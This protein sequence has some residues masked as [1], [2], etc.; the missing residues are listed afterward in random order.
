MDVTLYR[1]S[2]VY[3]RCRIITFVGLLHEDAVIS[4]CWIFAVRV[5][6]KGNGYTFMG[7]NFCQNCFASLLKREKEIICSP[8]NSNFFN[9][10]V[11]SFSEG[12]LCAGKR[13]K[14]ITL[15]NKCR[16]IY[17]VYPVSS[18]SLP[19][20]QIEVKPCGRKQLYFTVYFYFKAHIYF[21]CSYLDTLTHEV[22]EQ[23]NLTDFKES[24]RR[25]LKE[26]HNRIESYY[27]FNHTATA[28]REKQT[29]NN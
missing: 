10:R 1:L 8:L 18:S 6:V 23:M 17:Q 21:S 3:S 16:K 14:V 7:D 19:Y 29:L 9:F 20:Q 15:R 12:V 4:V 11:D 28:E 5:C 24:I 26:K 25:W 27:S 13:T 2:S 22:F